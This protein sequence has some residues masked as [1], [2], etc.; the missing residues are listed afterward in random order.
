[1]NSDNPSYTDRKGKSR[2]TL[3]GIRNIVNNWLNIFTSPL[4]WGN[5][6]KIMSFDELRNYVPSQEG[7]RVLL[8]GWRRGSSLGGGEFVA[9]MGVKNDDGGCVASGSGYYWERSLTTFHVWAEMFGAVGD[10]TTDDIIPLTN[11]IQ[12]SSANRLELILTNVYAISSPWILP[13]F[14]KIKGIENSTTILAKSG[15]NDAIVK[16]LNSPTGDYLT[17]TN[18]DAEVQGIVINGLRIEGGWGGPDDTTTTHTAALQIWAVGTRLN[19]VQCGYCSGIGMNLGGKSTTTVRYGAP[20]RY[21]DLTVSMV[22]EHGI[23]IGGSS[24]NHS[25]SLI[26]KNAGIK[27]HKTYD[28]IRFG[29]GGT[30]RGEQFHVWQSGDAQETNYYTN[31]VRYGLYL[32][33]WDSMISGCHFEGCAG[34]NIYFLGGRNSVDNVRCYSLWEPGYQVIFLGDGNSFEGHIGAPMNN[35][36]ANQVHGFAIGDESTQVQSYNIKARVY[37]CKFVNYINSAGGGMIEL[38]GGTGIS[39]ASGMG[40]IITGTIPT[41]DYLSL[42]TLEYKG[43]QSGLN[44]VVNGGRSVSAAG[45]SSSGNVDMTGLPT[46]DPKVVGRLWKNGAV[47]QVSAG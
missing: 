46:A 21:K 29:G 24:D 40:T 1:M 42:N 2:T 26:V 10:G 23:V 31:R 45:L 20:S 7:Q 12:Y 34:A 39:G 27:Q 3:S 44:I 47:V 14:S 22:G 35:T 25:T 41:T 33:A 13:S 30:T 9:R 36:A 17:I 11:A 37:G 38:R 19:A 4:G 32:A 16:T 5:L 8:N 43:I 6:Q 28:G 18:K 15:W